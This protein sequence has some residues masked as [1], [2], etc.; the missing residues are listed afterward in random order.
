M[1]ERTRRTTKWEE[2]H[3]SFSHESVELLDTEANCLTDEGHFL[4]RLQQKKSELYQRYYVVSDIISGVGGWATPICLLYADGGGI[5]GRNKRRWAKAAERI[6]RRRKTH[7][8][9]I[10]VLWR[11]AEVIK[12]A[13]GWCKWNFNFNANVFILN[14]ESYFLISLGSLL[15]SGVG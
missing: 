1:A 10:L 4:F 3:F 11:G 13:R 12:N 5:W 7:N 2:H 6:A 15:D 9:I 14:V 8:D